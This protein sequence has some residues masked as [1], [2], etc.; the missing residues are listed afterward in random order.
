MT[1]YRPITD[2]TT[3]LFE[4]GS[5]PGKRSSETYHLT[6]ASGVYTLD[7]E[8]VCYDDNTPHIADRVI[9]DLNTLDEKAA[10]ADYNIPSVLAEMLYEIGYRD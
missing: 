5:T 4:R 3:D 1:R 10:P 6:I 8:V 7:R 2:L 9:V